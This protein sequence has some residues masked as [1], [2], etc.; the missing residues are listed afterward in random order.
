VECNELRFRLD[1]KFLS[2]KV[3]RK[4]LVQ[5]KMR[6]TTID[7]DGNKLPLLISSLPDR[8]EP[9]LLLASDANPARTHSEDL[10]YRLGSSRAHGYRT[11]RQLPWSTQILS[12]ACLSKA[13][14]SSHSSA[15]RTC[16]LES[17]M[18]LYLCHTQ[19]W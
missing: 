2:S 8:A 14:R 17:R 16:T 18:V 13:I 3:E 10:D 4:E 5:G 19:T 1:E 11:S 9:R 15:E 6:Q 7:L 12:G